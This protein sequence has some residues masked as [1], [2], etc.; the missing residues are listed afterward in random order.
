[1]SRRP[2]IGLACGLA[3]G[4]ALAVAVEACSTTGA[5]SGLTI[6]GAASLKGALNAVSS[7]WASSNPGV[8]LVISTDSSAA[9]ETKIEQGA[10]ADVF[11]SADT[12]NPQKLIEKGLADGD[13]VRFA[14]N[15]LAVIVPVGNPAGIRTPLDLARSGVKIIGAG[16][17]VPIS[18][19][20]ARL[21]TN[22]ATQAGY[23][24]DFVKRYQANVTSQEDNVASVVSKIALGE[25]DAAIV[26]ATDA[27]AAATVST[28]DVPEAANV[29]ATYG[30]VVVR[31]SKNAETARAFL[32]WL[33]G[34]SGQAVLASFG[35]SA[36]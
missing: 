7:A 36:P 30:G 23:P 31:A 3:I 8:T 12:T 19:Y 34:P 29:P 2:A 22:L 20:A 9:L 10:P 26:Y 13:L 1:V 32:R 17:S 33:S 15:R 25:G 6:Y 28:I 14:I 35:F 27:K 18:T 4:L 16:D 11:L 21:V 5:P 24:L